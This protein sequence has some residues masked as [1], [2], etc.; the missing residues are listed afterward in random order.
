MPKEI[1]S[2]DYYYDIQNAFSPE[3]NPLSW[4]VY[5]YLQISKLNENL[6]R[7]IN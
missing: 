3:N 4:Q 7:H 6:F 1:H 2:E 5:M